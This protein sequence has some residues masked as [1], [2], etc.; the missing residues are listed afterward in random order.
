ML[1]P[2]ALLTFGCASDPQSGAG[3]LV[4]G[5]AF[6]LTITPV[7]VASQA[8]MIDEATE[9]EVLVRDSDGNESTFAM[10][11]GDDEVYENTEIWGLDDSEVFLVGR[12]QTASS[13]TDVRPRSR[14]RL[15]Q[16]MPI[17]SLLEMARP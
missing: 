14:S 8:D 6:E 4:A 16:R 1:A 15:A 2:L 9:I 12:N 11:E 13:S 5:E 17:F 3:Q 7:Y 10:Y